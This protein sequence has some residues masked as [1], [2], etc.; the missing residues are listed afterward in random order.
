MKEIRRRVTSVRPDDVYNDPFLALSMIQG[1]LPVFD[2]LFG[3]RF[4]CV[5]V[6]RDDL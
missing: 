3:S 6:L 1:H 5:V 2:L 4:V